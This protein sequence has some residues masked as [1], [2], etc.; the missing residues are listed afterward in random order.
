VRVARKRFDVQRLRV[1]AIDPI[2]NAAQLRKITQLLGLGGSIGHKRDG[3][4][5]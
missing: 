5:R 2:A 4:S 3:T 1:L